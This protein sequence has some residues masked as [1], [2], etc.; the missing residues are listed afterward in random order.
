MVE[1]AQIQHQRSISTTASINIVSGD[2]GILAYWRILRIWMMKFYCQI[3]SGELSGRFLNNYYF[4]G[5]K[6]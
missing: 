1:F 2:S 5:R 4:V 3:P 6:K